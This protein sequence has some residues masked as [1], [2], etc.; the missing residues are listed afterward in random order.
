MRPT[1]AVACFVV[2]AALA[3]TGCGSPPPEVSQKPPERLRLSTDPLLVP[4]ARDLMALT[5]GLVTLSVTPTDEATAF[6]AL[7]RGEV[8]GVFTLRTPTY[9]EQRVATGRD[10]VPGPPLTPHPVARDDLALVVPL[11]NSLRRIDRRQLAAVLSMQRTHWDGLHQLGPLTLFARPRGTSVWTALLAALPALDSP[12]AGLRAVATDRA[13]VRRV[14][15][16]EGAFGVCSLSVVK[17]LRLLPIAAGEDSLRAGQDGWPLVRNIV[18]VTRG[19][20]GKLEPWMQAVHSPE[21]VLAIAN[22][23]FFPLRGR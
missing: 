14:A 6:A 8:E 2:L 10:I 5:P 9:D 4:L 19:P 15:E 7:L 16:T 20:I 11:E 12:P 17:H 21:G 22:R 3:V 13:V 18:L 23:G 1:S